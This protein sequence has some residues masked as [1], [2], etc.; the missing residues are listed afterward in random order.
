[1]K[2][3][4]VFE[5]AAVTLLCAD[6]CPTASASVD[7][8][9]GLL[10]N[11]R[12]LGRLSLDMCGKVVGAAHKRAETHFDQA[13]V[14]LWQRQHASNLSRQEADHVL[15]RT[16]RHQHTNPVPDVMMGNAS[17]F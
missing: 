4:L 3:P 15:W 12:P 17:F 8:D 5:G 1:R 13:L 11:P 14:D 7:V 16:C 9:V 10:N 2:R 6:H